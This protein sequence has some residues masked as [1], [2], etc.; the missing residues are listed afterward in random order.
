MSRSCFP[1]TVKNDLTPLPPPAPGKISASSV[2]IRA[3]ATSRCPSR[4]FDVFARTVPRATGLF[5]FSRRHRMPSDGPEL[6]TW[7]LLPGV[8]LQQTTGSPAVPGGPLAEA[9][10]FDSPAEAMHEATAHDAAVLATDQTEDSRIAHFR[11]SITRLQHSLST[12]SSAGY[13]VTT[14]DSLPAAGQALPDGLG[15]PHGPNERFQI[16]VMLIV[17]LSQTS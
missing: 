3:A 8:S 10:A 15:Y 5:R 16:Y 14:Q 1:P 17:L 6:L 7:Y 12:P 9:V 2:P 11:G 4:R 13:P